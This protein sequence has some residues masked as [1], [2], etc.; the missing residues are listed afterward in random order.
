MSYTYLLEL[1]KVLD[2]RKKVLT[3]PPTTPDQTATP[4]YVQGRINAVDEF[5]DFLSDHFDK[6]LPRRL[7]KNR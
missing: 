1:Y 5:R 4:R 2:K 7:Q 3:T 6:K